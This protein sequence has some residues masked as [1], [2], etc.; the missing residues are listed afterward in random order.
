MVS[1]KPT[2]LGPATRTAA[3]FAGGMSEPVSCFAGKLIGEL[4]SKLTSD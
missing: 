3:D 4:T 2:G 1:D